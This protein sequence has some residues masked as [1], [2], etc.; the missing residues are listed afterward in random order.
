MDASPLMHS[1]QQVRA[2]L[3]GPGAPFELEAVQHLGQTVRAYK[4]AFTSLP[5]LINAGRAHGDREFIVY[6]EQRWSFARFFAAVDALAGQLQQRHGMQAGERVALAMRN[7][8]EWAIAFAAVAL[9]GAVPVPLNS[10][11]LSEELSA[12]LRDIQPRLLICDQA[13]HD[14][15]P[16][17]SLPAACD[18]VVVDSPNGPWAA[19]TAAGGPAPHTPALAPT[20]PALILFTSGATSQAK[21]VMS[22][23]RAVCQ[24]L[25][26]ID[27]IGAISAMTSQQAVQKMM[28]AGL[29][30]T[31]LTAVPLFHVS[32]LHAQLLVSLRHGRRLVFMHRWDPAQAL[33]L[34]HTEKV[35]QF[36]G[37]P[38][39]V[40]QLLNQPAFHDAAV[41]GSLMGLGFGGAGLSQK[42]IEAT[43][44]ARPQSL[45]GIGF[46]LTETNGVGAAVSGEL[47]AAHPRC[48]G[49][50]SPLMDIRIVD[51]NGH[52]Q[53]DG[54]EGEV[55]LRGV[56]V[57]DGY[58]NQPDAT[59]TA[60]TEGWFHTGDV[61]LINASGMLRIVDRIKDVINRNGEKIAAAEIESCLLQHPDV[62][63]AAVFAQADENTGEAVVAVVH[64][65][66]GASRTGAELQQHVAQH[67]AAYKVPQTIHLR[68]EAMPR[69]PAGKLLKNALKQAYAR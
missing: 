3:L 59:R 62:D 18:S 52:A 30:P 6:G 63:E 25:Y 38:S 19:L 14:R 56:S 22:N 54:Q 15:L 16:A 50:V 23:Q 68:G 39:M 17:G 26:N 7:C 9:V 36:N 29:M 55:W 47:F 45:S 21:G 4:K 49:L 35:T 69:N 41:S 57:M 27:F 61:G 28:A 58:W 44:A 31:T 2:Q 20:D 37:A 42:L 1:A 64:L 32:G 65:R 12:G 48:A 66:A 11:G 34:I 8:P 40:Q 53:A 46:G 33:Q 5:E 67:L 10:F 24:A 60:I 51:A 13:R 43:L